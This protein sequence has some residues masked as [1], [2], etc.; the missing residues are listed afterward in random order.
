MRKNLFK[1]G[2]K[3]LKRELNKV[4]YA[5]ENSKEKCLYTIHFKNDGD[6]LRITATD[7]YRLATTVINAISIYNDFE[8]TINKKIIK[9]LIKN[10]NVNN[11]IDVE[12]EIDNEGEINCL[13][14]KNADKEFIIK[15]EKVWYPRFLELINSIKTATTTATI[16]KKIF[17]N[18]I[19]PA[20]KL[21]SKDTKFVQLILTIS[22][23]NK[24]K[25]N[26][27]ERDTDLDFEAE[28]DADV[29]GEE[30][31][32]S[33]NSKYL[34][35]LIKSIEDDKIKIEITTVDRPIKVVDNQTIHLLMPMKEVKKWEI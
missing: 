32:I 33:F 21:H 11:D 8:F 1:I 15:H 27:K 34:L 16:D 29:T 23:D 31:K 24:I 2:A 12:A 20:H 19:E 35:D 5:S 7:S 14:F 18:T 6:K 13:F 28:V 22:N 17:K 10:L 25:I 30:I 4:S 3:N 9:S 26:A